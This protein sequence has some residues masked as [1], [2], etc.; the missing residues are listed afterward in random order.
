MKED[1]IM[2]VGVGFIVT[3]II[4]AQIWFHFYAS[5]EFVKFLSTAQSLPA[6]C[7]INVK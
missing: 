7:L 6:R 4:G 5:C 2:K 3:L 1:T